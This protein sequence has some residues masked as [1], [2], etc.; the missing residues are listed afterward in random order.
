MFK[1]RIEKER[2]MDLDKTRKGSGKVRGKIEEIWR[3][4]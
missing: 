4:G 3:R 2:R 1:K